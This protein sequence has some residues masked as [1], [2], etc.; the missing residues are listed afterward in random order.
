MHANHPTLPNLL[1]THHVASLATVRSSVS[2]LSRC[3]RVARPLTD[4]LLSAL[5]NVDVDVVGDS[6]DWQSVSQERMYW[7]LSLGLIDC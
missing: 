6:L 2:E 4:T 5:H 3:W 7:H 1:P